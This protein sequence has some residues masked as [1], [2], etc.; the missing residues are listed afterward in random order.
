M[1]DNHKPFT[2]DTFLKVSPFESD[3]GAIIGKTPTE[4]GRKILQESGLY[5][6]SP[7]D[8]IRAKCLDCVGEI[9]E[10]RKCVSYK[11]PLWHLRMGKN[12]LYGKEESE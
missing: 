4:V 11:C 10:I 3:C 9:S 2:S 6:K 7:L 5:E 8:A 1:T 12:P